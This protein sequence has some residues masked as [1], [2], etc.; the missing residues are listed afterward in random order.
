MMSERAIAKY[1]KISLVPSTVEDFFSLFAWEKHTKEK[2][3]LIIMALIIS[4]LLILFQYTTQ[5]FCVS[6]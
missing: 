1:P 5:S 6:E 3:T 2:K 4:L